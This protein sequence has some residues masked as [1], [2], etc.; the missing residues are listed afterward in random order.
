MKP[1][2]RYLIKEHLILEDRMQAPGAVELLQK[3]LLAFS[4]ALMPRENLKKCELALRA[5]G[6]LYAFVGKL[7]TPDYYG[8]V[9]ALQEGES[10]E[11]IGLYEYEWEP[12]WEESQGADPYALESLFLKSGQGQGTFYSLYTAEDGEPGELTA[13]GEKNGRQYRGVVPYAPLKEFPDA[14]RWF[15]PLAKLHCSQ[16]DLKK[17]DIHKLLPVCR[18]LCNL[19]GDRELYFAGHCFNF[20][21]RNLELHRKE[22]LQKYFILCQALQEVSRGAA[23]AYGE[24]ADLSTADPR[25]LV[26]DFLPDGS[27]RLQI[28]SL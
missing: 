17:T 20:S 4:M 13:F 23:Q 26:M 16:E 22:Q 14:G 27:Q 1:V 11:F 3:R 28:T 25:V 15:A 5:G 24:L 6:K 9:N 7:P 19:G 18:R 10:L 8:L 2:S 12:W 21:L